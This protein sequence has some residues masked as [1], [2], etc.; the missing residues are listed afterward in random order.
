MRDNL[1]GVCGELVAFRGGR[2]LAVVT[3]SARRC[4]RGRRG[5]QTSAHRPATQQHP[6]EGGGG[7]QL[8]TAEKSTAVIA[9][10][11]PRVNHIKQLSW[12]RCAASSVYSSLADITAVLR[13][14]VFYNGEFTESLQ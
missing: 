6:G 4:D 7:G 14:S 1:T 8:T 5:G 12:L 9:A 2:Q 3:T 10:T 11:A 13:V